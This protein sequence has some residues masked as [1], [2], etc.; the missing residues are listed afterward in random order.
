MA[1]TVDVITKVVESALRGSSTQ[2][3]QHFVR[4]G[5]QAGQKFT[6]SFSDSVSKSGPEMQKAF[7]RAAD[8]AGKLRVE[9]QKLTELQAKG[10]ANSKLIA[11]S[12]R[13][14]KARRE[15]ARAVRAATD[16]YQAYDRQTRDTANGLDALNRGASS[17]I[18]VFSNLTAG[19]RFGGLASDVSM[20]SSEL[21]TAGRAAG[22]LGSSFAAAGLIAGGVVI[23]GVAALTAGV[24]ALGNELYDLGSVWDDTFD[25]IKVATGASGEMLD[26]I[27]DSVRAVAG[28]VPESLN[29]IGDIAGEVATALKLVGPEANGV[30]TA[31][32]QLKSF[33]VDVDIRD[34]GRAFRALGVEQDDYV[35]GLEQL[36]AAQ[37]ETGLSI[38]DML[39]SIFS[40]SAALQN[41]GF[42][43]GETVSLLKT[44]EAAGM[45]PDRAITALNKAAGTLADAGLPATKESLQSVIDE[46]QRLIA[47]GDDPAATNMMEKL[48][49]AR[50]GSS[51]LRVIKD[52]TFDLANLAA[53]ADAPRTSI[54]GLADDTYDLSE[55]WQLFKNEASVALGPLSEQVFDFVNQGLGSILDWIGE[56]KVTIIDFFIGVGDV[57]I[58]VLDGIQGFVA[59]T[60]T[61]MG[62][63][64]EIVADVLGGMAAFDEFLNKIPGMGGN[65]AEAAKLR[66]WQKSLDDLAESMQGAGKR[67]DESR[68]AWDDIRAKWE[69]A[70]ATAKEAAAAIDEQAEA[71]DKQA[72]ANDNLS[73]SLVGLQGIGPVPGFT[74][75]TG[76]GFLGPSAGTLPPNIPAP[77]GMQKFASA[78]SSGTGMQRFAAMR[79]NS[80]ASSGSSSGGVIPEINW[81]K[82]IAEQYNLSFSSGLRPGDKG[83]HGQ[84]FAGDFSNTRRFGA[85]TPEMLNFA[86]FMAN[87]FAP[88]I[89]ELIFQH[90]SFTR[91]VKDGQFVGPMG[92]GQVFNESQAGYHGDHVHIAFKPG[93]FAG[94]NAMLSFGP[95][96][97]STTTPP[98]TPSPIP[99]LQEGPAGSTFGYNPYGEPGYYRPDPKSVRGAERRV[100]DIDER[101]ADVQE[102]LAE[103]NT[104]LDKV[105][106]DIL[107]SEEEKKRVAKARD[108]VKKQ[109]DDLVED[110]KEAQTDLEETQR[111]RFSP[112]RE[113][114]AGRGGARGPGQIGTPLAADFGIGGGLPGIA[115]WVTGFLAN[116]AFAPMI[117]ALS[118]IAGSSPIQG[119]YGLMGIMGAQNLAAG[120]SPLGLSAPGLTGAVTPPSPSQ[121]GP[122]PLGGG[123][124]AP[125]RGSGMPPGRPQSPQTSQSPSG[126]PGGEGFQGIGGLPL[127]GMQMAGMAADLM[128]PGMGQAAQTGI[129]VLNRTAGYIGQL[130]AIGIGGLMETFLPNNSAAADPSKSWL[131]RIAGGLAGARPA[132]PNAAGQSAPPQ[133]PEE[134]AALQQQQGGSGGGT[135]G[136]M[137]QVGAINN[138]TPDGGQSLANQ[139]GRMQMAGYSSGGKR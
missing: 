119:G 128:A 138:Y 122:A 4:T 131:G 29:V 76:P 20:L 38:D 19:T 102:R 87:N 133:S 114:T 89:S 21:A 105:N 39:G 61:D 8:A 24:V 127:A 66:E 72:K 93:A 50:S 84:G 12:E 11:Q 77:P 79:G 47:I 52:G 43:F 111:G 71:T 117:G 100:Q 41:F 113:A 126:G 23:A 110:R 10:A 45:S 107:A 104:E 48:F 97:S 115:E 137:V 118:A 65:E 88:Y 109:L 139:I 32:G 83:Y 125:H 30:V 123:M 57:T 112:A 67:A 28:E 2:V 26:Q 95:N 5:E 55:Q 75:G 96:Q 3:E 85:P 82:G 130:G 108:R 53:A 17:L 101:I 44:F 13:V 106:K 78:Q 60:L 51:W 18:N 49:G 91:N 116:L 33:G 35:S 132:T 136:P 120:G 34:L 36:M 68:E 62:L 1:I 9:T 94:N 42:T 73:D 14:E 63:L 92:P 69:A 58:D 56:N 134:A 99:G 54:Q 121:I 124:G 25:G 27:K 37:Q 40:G 46:V 86:N 64:V 98:G 6:K 81:A 22:G 103:A 16:A 15:E 90:P 129:E 7:D 59:M 74:T 70:G 31:L 80:A 135:T